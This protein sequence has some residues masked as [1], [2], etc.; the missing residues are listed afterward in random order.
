MK[1]TLVVYHYV[2]HYRKAVFDEL[3]LAGDVMLAA[4]ESSNND[5]EM[6]SLEE[7]FHSSEY[8]KLENR[9]FGKE[10]LWQKKL[11]SL[12]LKRKFN[13]VIFL[14]SPYFISTWFSALLV[15]I[16]GGKVYFWTHGFVRDNSLKER[17]KLYFYFLANGLL[18]YGHHAR[19][20]LLK[21]G[22]PAEKIHVIYNS[23][24]YDNQKQLR[25]AITEQQQKKL[26]KELFKVPEYPQLLYVGRLTHHKKLEMLLELV[27]TLHKNGIPVNLLFVG[28]GEA[29]NKL[30][31]LTKHKGVEPLVNFYGSCHD[32]TILASLISSSDVCISPGEVGL[33]AMHCLGYGVP[34]ITHSDVNHQMPEFE[35]IIDKKTGRLFERDSFESLYQVTLEF[36]NEPIENIRTNCIEEIEKKYTPKIQAKLIRRAMEGTDES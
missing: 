9:W 25:D 10:V 17:L 35:A 6:M 20:N 28:D 24:D 12:I 4:G 32:E 14:A 13:N 15:R 23:L 19:S 30:V 3:L 2:P 21:K 11:L 1:K 31:E 34:V 22:L 18:L 29:K 26:K 7:S 5:I 16:L 8:V 27:S 36:I 33:T